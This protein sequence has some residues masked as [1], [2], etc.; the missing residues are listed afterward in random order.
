M[1]LKKKLPVRGEHIFYCCGA[2]VRVSGDGVEVL[3]EPTVEF[4]PLH[5]MLYKTGT[6]DKDAVIRSVILKIEKTGFGC[7]HRMF[8]SSNVV[9]FGAS[10]MIRVCMRAGLFDCAVTV[11]EGAGTVISTNPD[12]VQEIGA[13]LT[14]IVKTSPVPEIIGHIEDRGGIL[15]D[16][17][18]ALIDQVEGIRRAIE[19]GHKKIAVTVSGFDADKIP[20]IRSMKESEDIS[21]TVFSVCNTCIRD[22]DVD[23]LKKADLVWASA[24]KIVRERIGSIALL[25]IGVAIPVFALTERG[26]EVVLTYLRE[27]G[28]KIVIFRTKKLPYVVEERVP[29]TRQRNLDQEIKSEAML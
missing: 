1:K 15:L 3:D 9:P 5:E 21:V 23:N 6:I 13:F 4:C 2:R 25:Q 26:K 8:T 24:S 14:G 29:K 28:D 10:E 22:T 17:E 20:V 27:F 12:L 16:R 11:C 19:L 7:P 18:R